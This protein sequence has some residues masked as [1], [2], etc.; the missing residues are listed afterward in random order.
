[1]Q[2]VHAA[3][4]THTINRAMFREE[5]SLQTSPLSWLGPGRTPWQSEVDGPGAI[6]ENDSIHD[7]GDD[8]GLHVH[9]VQTGPR[10]ADGVQTKVLGQKASVQ[11]PA[12][13]LCDPDGINHRT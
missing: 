10:L 12:I 11:V 7:S 3:F 1:M 5:S 8:C 9:D 6:L 13:P 4:F 2:T